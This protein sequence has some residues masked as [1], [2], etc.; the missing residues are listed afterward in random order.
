MLTR[1][2]TGKLKNYSNKPVPMLPNKWNDIIQP[3][4]V[5]SR[6]YEFERLKSDL[7]KQPCKGWSEKQCNALP[8]CHYTKNK[9]TK[10]RRKPLRERLEEEEKK[11]IHGDKKDKK[12]DV[13]KDVDLESCARNDSMLL[14]FLLA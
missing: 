9:T 8:N 7:R 12:E 14:L 3:V 11:I 4:L 2:L 13:D 6:K 1:G 10:C 5:Y